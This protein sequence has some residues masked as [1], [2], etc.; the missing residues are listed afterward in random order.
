[1]GA[2][3]TGIF[4]ADIS[5]DVKDDYLD[6]L[7]AGRTDPEAEDYACR[8][9]GLL[10]REEQC[11]FWTALAMIQWKYGRL[12]DK[13]KDKAIQVIDDGGDCDLFIEKSDKTKRLKALQVCK[14]TILS[15]MPERK[16]VKKE[17]PFRLSPWK[18]GDVFAYRI[19]EKN[20]DNAAFF[21]KYFVFVITHIRHHQRAFDELSFDDISCAVYNKVFDELP[22]LK[23]VKRTNYLR[24]F[25]YDEECTDAS[26]AIFLA[27]LSERELTQF[28]K[29]TEMIGYKKHVAPMKFRFVATKTDFKHLENTLVEAYQDEKLNPEKSGFLQ[30]V[31]KRI[32]K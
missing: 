6:A 5:L 3:G 16:T 23:D 4:S 30:S 26:Y 25:D 17:K 18:T 32:W 22:R 10:D 14:E 24:I 12:S 1:M 27:W 20:P 8:E 7:K 31:I 13:V 19:S 21:G 29:Q 11:S 9:V 15:P 28:M 2:W